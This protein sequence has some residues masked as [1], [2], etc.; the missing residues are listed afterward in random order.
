MTVAAVNDPAGDSM[1]E[2]TDRARFTGKPI[3]KKVLRPR[4][5]VEERIRA[6]ILAGELRSGERLPSEAELARQFGVS[7]TTVREALRSLS[8]ANL[9]TKTPGAAGGSFV[10]SVDYRSLGAV[11]QESMHN[12][13]ALGSV[14]FEEVAIVR[15][16]LEVPSVR[17]A[18]SHRSDQ[19]LALLRAIVD[20]QRTTSVD[21]PDVPKLDE[22]FHT[23][24]AQASG[25]RVLASF[26]HALHHE[27]EP[28]HYLDL[29]P[30]V[31]RETVRQHLRIVAAIADGDPDAGERAIIEHL[32]YL[33]KHLLSHRRAV[34]GSDSPS[35][36]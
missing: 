14:D 6:A 35:H 16:H 13:L 9:I 1:D 20:R 24:I 15:Q 11:L 18:A 4:Q 31:G 12:L 27:T 25:N 36:P 33:R 8:A 3:G 26:V 2:R 29:S 23:T 21:D 5:Q 7:R 32:T 10:R 22:Q 30:E 28:V 17:L 34:G 19:D